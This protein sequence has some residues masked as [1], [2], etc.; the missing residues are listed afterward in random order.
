MPHKNGPG[1]SQPAVSKAE[2]KIYADVYDVLLG[3]MIVSTAL[4]ALGV[5]LALIH[6]RYVPLTRDYI[7]RN[8]NWSAAVHG[9]LTFRP[10]ALMMVATLLLILTPVARVLISV[11]A[12]HAGRD[13]KYVM[14]TGAVFIVIILTVV[15]GSLGLQ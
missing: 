14:V 3:G 7:L 1:A 10:G 2:E 15:L 8:Y 13:H 12:F 4:F 11:Y 9:L 6:P 5:V